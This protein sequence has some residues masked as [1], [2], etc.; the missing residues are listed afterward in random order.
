MTP[1][2]PQ[3][4][5]AFHMLYIYIITPSCE[6]IMDI[7]I[8]S[9]CTI[10]VNQTFGCQTKYKV[11]LHLYMRIKSQ[12]EATVAMHQAISILQ[13]FFLTRRCNNIYSI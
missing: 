7:A 10:F 1:L 6:K 12:A 9:I 2:F 8:N 4:K 5:L 3:P 13:Y 11:H